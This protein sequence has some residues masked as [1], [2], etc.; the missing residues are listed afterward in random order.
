MAITKIH[1]IKTTVQSA[2]DYICNPEKTDGMILVDT[3]CCGI[4]TAALDFEMSNSQSERSDTKNKAFHLIQSFVPGEVSFEEAHKIGTELADKLLDGKHSYVI[5]THIDRNHVHNHIIFGATENYTHKRYYDN[6]KNY[7]RIR[8]LSDEIC[9]EHGLS[10]IE[11]GKTK[12]MDYSEWLANH[13]NNSIKLQLKKDIYECIQVAQDYEEFIR[14]MKEKEYEIKGYELYEDAAKYISFK[15]TG[16]GNYIRGSQRTL[17][18]AYT[19]EAI[20]NRIENKDELRNEWLAAQKNIPLSEQD[21]IDLTEE[22]YQ[23]NRG[24]ERWA[25]IHNVKVVSATLIELGSGKQYQEKMK[26]LNEE[27]EEAR[28]EWVAID[29]ELRILKEQ[30]YNLKNYE[31]CRPYYIAYRNSKNPEKYLQENES[32]IILYNGSKE[33]LKRYGINPKET[34]SKDLLIKIQ[35][36]NKKKETAKATYK[37]LK[38]EMS[39]LEKQYKKIEEYVNRPEDEPAIQKQTKRKKDQQSL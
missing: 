5:A 7:Y 13:K 32:K 14:M 36:L 25:R 23:N 33:M 26:L 19:K 24:L 16:Y 17:G 15:P 30:L 38:E 2:V 20:L 1:A 22:K 29:K 4:Q 31:E 37:S 21:L 39:H 28:L 10:I 9:K 6:K 8:D 18:K 34:T 35:D 27:A 3:Y 12:G 11:P